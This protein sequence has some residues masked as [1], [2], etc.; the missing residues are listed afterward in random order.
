M[1]F[2]NNVTSVF[3]GDLPAE[4]APARA[5]TVWGGC[6]NNAVRRRFVR[7]C[8]FKQNSRRPH[9]IREIKQ[10][11]CVWRVY[12]RLNK[13]LHLP[14]LSYHFSH[15]NSPNLLVQ[16]GVILALTFILFFYFLFE[17]LPSLGCH[18]SFVGVF[19]RFVCI[20]SLKSVNIS[21]SFNAAQF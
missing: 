20:M 3:D 4:D 14:S 7:C 19:I 6:S 15:F 18:Y 9:V 1:Y 21:F 11:K 13:P 17:F 12:C 2:K 16:C 5:C 8:C 10:P